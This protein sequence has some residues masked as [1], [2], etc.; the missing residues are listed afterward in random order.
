M[1]PDRELETLIN[2][3][4]NET[5]D[6]DGN[7]KLEQILLK[8]D[9]ALKLYLEYVDAQLALKREAELRTVGDEVSLAVDSV[10]NEVPP[11]SDDANDVVEGGQ[12]ERIGRTYTGRLSSRR[13]FG[14][15]AA[16]A[17]AVL[18]AASWHFAG[19]TGLGT[20]EEVVLQS[21]ESSSAL[22]QS[23][24]QHY[25]SPAI[26][27]VGALSH[28]VAWAVGGLPAD[29]F[30][31]VSTGQRLKLLSGLAELEYYSGARVILH[32]PCEYEVTGPCSGRLTSGRV[33]GRVT[34][35]DFTLDTPSAHVVDLGTEFG[36][37]VDGAENT[38]VYV[39]KGKV[40]LAS[41]NS[42]KSSTRSSILLT[43]GMAARATAE[44]NL[45]GQVE[46]DDKSFSR[47]IPLPPSLRELG[48]LSLVD[49]VNGYEYG[50]YRHAGGIAPDTGAA[51][52]R[53]PDAG[54]VRSKDSAQGIYHVTSW[55]PVVDGVFIPSRN[56]RRSTINSTGGVVDL[57]DCS[58][59][60]WGPV[61]ARRR[62]DAA[63]AVTTDGELWG[64]TA[65]DRVLER[66]D[67]S[68]WGMIGLHSN[69]GITFDLSAVRTLYEQSPSQFRARLINLDNGFFKHGAQASR[70]FTA[71]CRF[72]VDGE[73]RHSR[74]GFARAD[75]EENVQFAIHEDDRFLTVVTTEDGDWHRD[76]VA[77]I[78]PFLIFEA[79]PSDATTGNAP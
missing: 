70:S 19:P 69:V 57:P 26:G 37:S 46:V 68:E 76:Q 74:L 18:I 24:P 79:S 51:F 78:D 62:I 6:G 23:V 75:D 71:D 22:E 35:C 63:G 58:A 49:A 16:L 32:G 34:D 65:A 12:A 33:T 40:R 15:V 55:H 52:R 47:S 4:L 73:L 8:D 1:T 44:G 31:E 72:F 38:D 60:T 2:A 64:G 50:N 29:F 41:L 20:P 7:A 13:V 43:N 10:S 67:T 11:A 25:L 56:G 28:D 77:L 36:A 9:Q 17:A 48:K 14:L 59:V 54:E 39:F 53:L 66:M 30:L 45:D 27:Q 3:R 21:G 42:S 5:L 61:W